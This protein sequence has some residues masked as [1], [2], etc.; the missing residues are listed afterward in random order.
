ERKALGPIRNSAAVT[1]IW[2]ATPP[3][4]LSL[5]RSPGSTQNRLVLCLVARERATIPDLVCRFDRQECSG[6]SGRLRLR[7]AEMRQLHEGPFSFLARP[8][9]ART[10]GRY[11]EPSCFKHA[12]RTRGVGAIGSSTSARPRGR[13]TWFRAVKKP[14]RSC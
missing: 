4:S 2:R 6:G 8:A 1:S 11:A 3:G 12:V 13:L 9:C 5:S 10:R 7:L 14:G